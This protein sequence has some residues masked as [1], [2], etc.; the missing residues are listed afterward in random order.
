MILCPTNYCNYIAANA[1]GKLRVVI[2]LKALRVRE[3]QCILR[4]RVVEQLNPGI[5]LFLNRKD[6]L[7]PRRP[8]LRDARVTENIERKQRADCKRQGKQKHL[9]QPAVICNHGKEMIDVNRAQQDRVL[10]TGRAVHSLHVCTR[11]KRRNVLREYRRNV[12]RLPRPTMKRH[13]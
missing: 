13:T 3:M 7:R 4:A 8:T 5:L 10:K 2:E 11:R 12:S 6:F 1:H 9:E